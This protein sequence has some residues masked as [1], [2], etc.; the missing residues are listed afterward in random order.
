MEHIRS[1]GNRLRTS[2]KTY[3]KT[4]RILATCWEPLRTWWEHQYLEK[5][6]NRL[7]PSK[8]PKGKKMGPPRL[9]VELAQSL[10]GVLKLFVTIVGFGTTPSLSM[11][12]QY[13]FVTSI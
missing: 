13:L 7:P 9:H 11:W 6:G 8:I 3:E 5:K 2:L 12:V 4:L 10:H 1:L